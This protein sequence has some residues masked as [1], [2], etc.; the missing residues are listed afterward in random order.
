M[1][2]LPK[3]RTQRKIAREEK[4]RVK[5]HLSAQWE[6]DKSK[7]GRKKSLN[8]H[9]GKFIDALGERVDPLEIAAVM[10][11]TYF[12]HGIITTSEDF[13]KRAALPLTQFRIERFASAMAGTLTFGLWRPFSEIPMTEAEKADI[14]SKYPD[15]QIWIVSFVIAYLVVHNFGDLAKAGITGIKG[16]IGFLLPT[17]V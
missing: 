9:L 7:M 15:W 8:D 14:E 6:F 17:A 5:A 4:A 2:Q 16:L 1:G 11:A 10:G 13:L 12:V 3:S